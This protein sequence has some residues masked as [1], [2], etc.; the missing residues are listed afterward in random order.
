[1]HKFVTI[2]GIFGLV[3]ILAGCSTSSASNSP[4]EIKII[5]EYHFYQHN[6]IP[7]NRPMRVNTPRQRFGQSK[8]IDPHYNHKLDQAKPKRLG[9]PN[10]RI[11]Q[12]YNHK[13]GMMPPSKKKT[14]SQEK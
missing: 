7:M 13:P 8:G 12:R 4:K 14:E 11:D 3:L 1:M 5:H 6:A 2:F 9:N 10:N